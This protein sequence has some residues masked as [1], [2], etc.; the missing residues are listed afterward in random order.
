MQWNEITKVG[1]PTR[2]EDVNDL[3]QVV[4]VKECCNQG[5]PPKADYGFE[6]PEM[7]WAFNILQSF[8]NLAT[9]KKF[10]V[11]FKFQFHLIAHLDDTCG[12]KRGSLTH[13][14]QFPF[15]LL[16]QIHWSKNIKEKQDALDQI[17]LGAIDA[18]YYILLALS[19]YL[20]EWTEGGDGQ[21]T[22]YLFCGE[23]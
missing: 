13:C 6:Q 8:L 10:L 21:L 19:A 3:I 7:E 22:D 2:S 11:M 20:E 9:K 17:I 4:I 16:F 18:H 12:I 23:G 14:F 5:K 1:S 15:V